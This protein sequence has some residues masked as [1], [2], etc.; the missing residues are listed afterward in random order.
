[1]WRERQRTE[2]DNGSINDDSDDD[3]TDHRVKHNSTR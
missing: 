1:V 3:A 2:R